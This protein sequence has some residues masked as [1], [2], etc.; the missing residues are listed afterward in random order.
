MLGYLRGD[1]L[2]QSVAEGYGTR[3]DMG[4]L[5]ET[6]NKIGAFIEGRISEIK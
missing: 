6:A 3:L 2:T 5:C 4:V 1:K